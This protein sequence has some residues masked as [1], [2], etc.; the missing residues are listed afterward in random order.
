MA[1]QDIR[2]IDVRAT[3]QAPANTFHFRFRPSRV[4]ERF[5]PGCFTNAYNARSGLKRIEL[6]EDTLQITLPEADAE[7]YV[8]V[9][10]QVVEQANA[11]Y[12]AELARQV[13]ARQRQL[14]EEQARQSRGAALQQQAKRLL[15]IDEG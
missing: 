11:A 4:P 5:W 7:G 14:D 12:V 8:A 10:E 2:V 1:F 15:G 3:P 13:A 9:V 6:S